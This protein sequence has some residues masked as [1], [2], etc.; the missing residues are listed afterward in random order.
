L[1]PMQLNFSCLISKKNLVSNRE[2]FSIVHIVFY[3]TRGD[4]IE[5]SYSG[6]NTLTRDIRRCIWWGV[7]GRMSWS[8]LWATIVLYVER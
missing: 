2:V 8:F 5:A 7:G 1:L 3:A 6:D 4:A